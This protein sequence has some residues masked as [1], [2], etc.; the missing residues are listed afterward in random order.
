V[1]ALIRKIG[2]ACDTF[3][4]NLP[5]PKRGLLSAEQPSLVGVDSM[6]E[7]AET[8]V[9]AQREQWDR[10]SGAWGKWADLFS[11]RNDGELYLRLGEIGLGQR[12]LEVGAGTGDQTL[13][14]ARAVGPDGS[15]VATDLSEGMLAVAHSRVQAAGLGN[16]EFLAGDVGSLSLDDE[17][18]DAAVA[19]FVLMLVPE[20]ERVAA[21]VRRKLSPGGRFVAS[22]WSSPPAVPMLAMPM[23]TALGEVGGA[24]PDPAAPGLF[25][26][27]DRQRLEQVLVSAGFEDVTVTPFSFLFRFPSAGVYAEFMREIAPPISQ[28]IAERAPGKA[29]TVWQKVEAAARS[30]AADDGSVTF[31]NGM[32]FISGRRP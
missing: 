18:F 26:L 5:K 14:L 21:T 7:F 1:R 6:S 28:L 32:L 22:V 12:V 17:S 24:P 29:D 13:L 8:A 31:D 3:R 11:Q 20:P 30:R 15:V 4:Q 10:A 19:G 2:A 23:M 9:A 25:A 16:V 27:A